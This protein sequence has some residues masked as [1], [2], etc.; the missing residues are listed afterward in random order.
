LPTP[1][2]DDLSDERTQPATGP[3]HR[4][5]AAHQFV[6]PAHHVQQAQHRERRHRAAHG[7]ASAVGGLPLAHHRHPD[8]Q[9]HQRHQEPAHA[10]EPAHHGLHATPERPGE[11]DVDAQAEQH[12][13]GDERD[14]AELVVATLHRLAQFRG[15]AAALGGGGLFRP[16]LSGGLGC[17]FP[18]R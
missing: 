13:D 9:Q 4:V 15:G 2:N 10:G 11:V 5:E 8:A 14:A 6:R 1:D 12:A 7:E 3:A 16:L 17:H 18:K